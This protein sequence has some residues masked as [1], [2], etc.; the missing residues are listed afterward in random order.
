MVCYE[1]LYYH[2]R[3]SAVRITAF[4]AA[5]WASAALYSLGRCRSQIFDLKYISY[6]PYDT[7]HAG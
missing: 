7:A 2:V 3:E 4:H 6:E 1:G 5:A